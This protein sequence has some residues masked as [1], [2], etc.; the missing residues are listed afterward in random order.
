MRLRRCAHSCMMLL[1]LTHAE[2]AEKIRALEALLAAE[3]DRAEAERE[4]RE[5]AEE[6]RALA[7]RQLEEL[8]KSYRILQQEHELLRRRIHE[9]RAERTDPTQLLMEFAAKQAALDELQKKIEPATGAAPAA[10]PA[11][12][13]KKKPSGRRKLDEAAFPEERVVIDDPRW[14]RSSL[15][16]RPRSWA[17]P[18]TAPR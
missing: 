1:V 12:S 7:E 13:E 6:L 15:A 8:R 11:S 10:P 14:R 3:R 18:T 4:K 9:A 2:Q 17:R 5:V 16:A